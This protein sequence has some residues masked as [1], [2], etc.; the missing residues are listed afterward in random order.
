[1]TG[2]P[3]SP[4]LKALLRNAGAVRSDAHN[5]P[6]AIGKLVLD[7]VELKY[8]EMVLVVERQAIDEA[9]EIVFKCNRREKHRL[10]QSV[11]KTLRQAYPT[12]VAG[13]YDKQTADAF[14]AD[15]VLWTALAEARS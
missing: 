15:V 12:I 3:L 2:K 11:D 8:G 5:T 14:Y 4:Q 10:Q 6:R 13:R 7:G 1:M 9:R